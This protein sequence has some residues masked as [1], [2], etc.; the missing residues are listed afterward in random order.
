ML[1]LK[2]LVKQAVAAGPPAAA[3][4]AT[5]R[6]P[7][8][9][10]AHRVVWGLWWLMLIG[11]PLAFM[12]R[13]FLDLEVYRN[14][15]LAWWQGIPLYL[16]FPGPLPG[17]RLPF[18]YPPVAAVLFSV[19]AALPGWLMN[20]LVLATSFLAMTAVCV[21][22]AGKLFQR[23]EIAWTVG[24]GAAVLSIGMEPVISTL[25]FGQINIMLMALVVIDC[26]AVRD[27]RWRGVL[28]GLA[29]AIKLT[30]AVF[31]LYF[32][33]HR[34]WRAAVNSIGAFVVLALIG[35]LVAPTDSTEYWFH[36]LIDPTRIGG[37]AYAPNQ[38][39]RGLLHRLNPGPDAISL[40]WLGLAALVMLLAVI[41]ALRTR[42]EVIAL[43]AIAAG[44]LLASPVSWSHHW[45][46]CV[47]AFLVAA[48]RARVWQHWAL[49]LSVLALYCAHLFAMVPST[50]D[51]ELRWTLWQHI[52]GNA[53]I[54]ITL[55]ALLVLAIRPVR[56][57]LSSR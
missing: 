57:R 47:P 38:S 1:N 19:F 24:A 26:F 50:E 54:W 32:L 36:A 18:T 45:V 52:P 29:A 44:A 51:R 13:Y 3:H 35:F 56:S 4:A 9:E 12:S 30:P 25:A 23:R 43:L 41:V 20:T 15:G 8:W 48:A 49:L 16:D 5:A 37:L 42:D 46:W 21:L 17:P 55:A 7:R 53:Y 22:V 6:S 28:V 11:L 31:V 34:D 27:P 2:S 14:G 33:I 40:L 10:L 39:L